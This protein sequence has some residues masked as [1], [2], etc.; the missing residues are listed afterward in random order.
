[1]KEKIIIVFIALFLGASMTTLGFL[2]YKQT[3]KQPETKTNINLPADFTTNE[4]SNE[5]TSGILLNVSEP[6]DETVV[7][8][9]TVIVKGETNPENMIIVSSN[10]E[11][12]T[13]VPSKDGKF[14][15]SVTIDSGLNKI[16]TRS[17]SPNGE[18]VV[19]ERTVTYS[20]EEF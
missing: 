18:E 7:D 16:I 17:I 19:D 15:L 1:M 3:Q 6:L 4:A 11:E 10:E 14:S 9:R 12:V 5:N 20:T 13:G 2:I 8:K